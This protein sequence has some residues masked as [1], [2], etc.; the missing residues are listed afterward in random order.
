MFNL[1]NN[2]DKYEQEACSLFIKKKFPSYEIFWQKFIV[3]LTNRVENIN[4]INLTIDSKLQIR[5]PTEN[6]EKIHERMVIFQLHY[7]A[8]RML[9]KT[10]KQISQSAKDLD[11]LENCF[12]YLYSALDISAELFARYE[13]FK[14]NLPIIDDPFNPQTAVKNSMALR[15][16]WQRNKYPYPPDIEEIRIYRN[17]MLHGQMFACSATQGAGFLHLPNVGK[18]EN[19]IDWRT[20]FHSCE[21]GDLQ[22]FMWSKNIAENSFN[23]VINFLEQ[24]WQKNLLTD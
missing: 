12:S 19:Y 4:D 8:L 24:E 15:R 6:I 10:R 16:D 3:Q 5:F 20:V 11:S 9:L 1:I 7:S 18:I 13:R 22:D 21:I 2:G 17:M 14:N 23:K